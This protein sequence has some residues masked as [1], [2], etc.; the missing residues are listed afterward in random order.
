MTFE[1][2][3]VWCVFSG[4]VLAGVGWLAD[5]IDKRLDK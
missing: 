4:L 5:F 3:I 1:G 2:F